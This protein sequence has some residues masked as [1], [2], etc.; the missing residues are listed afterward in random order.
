M[1][2]A[3]PALARR[4]HRFTRP[5]RYTQDGRDFSYEVRFAIDEDLGWR[6]EAF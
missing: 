3:S 1:P 6:I 5:G 2:R 4:Q